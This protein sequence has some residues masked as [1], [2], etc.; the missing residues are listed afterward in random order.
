MW[1]VDSTA[2][3]LVITLSLLL[4]VGCAVQRGIGLPDLSDWNARTRT[5]A[6]LMDWQFKGRIGVST[7]NEGFNGELRY[8]QIDNG[9]RAMVSG[10]LGFGTIRLEGYGRSITV[11]DK[12]GEEWILTDPE[13][14]LHNMYGW[15]IPVTN[16]RF[17]VLGIPNPTMPADTEFNEDGLLVSLKQ[18]TWLIKIT[19]YRD[20]GG[21]LMPRRLSAISG[22]NKIRLVIDNW[23]F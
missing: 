22:E 10:P 16:L 21:Q 6:S 18:D 9:F 7:G 4:I 13:I 11:I 17:W 2:R 23:I 20:G 3:Y 15:T 1:S 12:D 19:Q 14:D 8:S 5:L